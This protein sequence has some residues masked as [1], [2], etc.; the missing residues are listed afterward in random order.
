MEDDGSL[1]FKQGIKNLE[2]LLASLI[3]EETALFANYPNPFNPETWIPYQLA[4][5][6]DVTLAIYDMNGQL[7]RRLVVGHQA[8]GM[9]QSRSRAVYWDGRNQLGES[10]A[11]GLY[12][13][14][15]TAGDFTETRRML[16]LK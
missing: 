12:F 3:P 10:V 7:V 15:L 1:A 8:V 16:I 2:N 14:T 11:S 4:E 13:Y 6:A 9:Y 5:P